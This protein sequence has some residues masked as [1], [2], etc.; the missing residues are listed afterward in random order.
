MYNYS[1]TP[2]ICGDCTDLMMRGPV[3]V[4]RETGCAD[5]AVP[6]CECT[7]SVG[8]TDFCGTADEASDFPLAI[9]SSPYQGFGEVFDCPSEALSQG[10]LF[11]NLVFPIKDAQGVRGRGGCGI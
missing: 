5:I 9:V 3:P 10:T 1:G 6:P 11:A 2:R 7:D 8:G 4:R